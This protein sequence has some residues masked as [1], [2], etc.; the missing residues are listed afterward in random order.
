[1]MLVFA[2]WSSIA[3]AALPVGP[4]DAYEEEQ[5]YL[6]AL[7]QQ[8]L[9]NL[10]EHYFWDADAY[11][12]WLRNQSPLGAKDN[13]A[14]HFPGR[15]E[16]VS[17][18]VMDTNSCH[19]YSMIS[20]SVQSDR[21]VR[22]FRNRIVSDFGDLL[23]QCDQL[24]VGIREKRLSKCS[25]IEFAGHSTQSTGLDTVFGIDLSRGQETIL[26]SEGSVRELGKCLRSVSARDAKVVMSVCGG[27]T[28]KNPDGTWGRKFHWAG[29]E[30]SQ[31]K[32]AALLKMPVL[33]GVGPVF[34]TSNGGVASPDGWHWS[35]L[36]T[37]GN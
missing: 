18:L 32:L 2:L 1:M 12:N 16:F 24:R 14:A 11:Q 33:A 37:V 28:S 20:P 35:G 15:D 34:G 8:V 26:P 23:A 36:D 25:S 31:R 5:R 22:G 30:E 3:L 10:P 19:F 4:V 29:K 9:K 21:V 27:E 13:F 17:G 7:P 6:R